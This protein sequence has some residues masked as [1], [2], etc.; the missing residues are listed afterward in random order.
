MLSS[1]PQ[2][3]VDILAALEFGSTMTLPVWMI[4]RLAP[5]ATADDLVRAAM[6]ASCL[7]TK[8]GRNYKFERVHI[9]R[10]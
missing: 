8:V 1:V 9:Q 7:I 6:A 2:R 10:H 4:E 3:L 5:N